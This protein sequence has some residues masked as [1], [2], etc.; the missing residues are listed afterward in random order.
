[1]FVV[2]RLGLI[3]GEAE[4]E[5]KSGLATST[6]RVHECVLPASSFNHSI[7]QYPIKSSEFEV[8]LPLESISTWLK[9]KANVKPLGP[10]T[11]AHYHI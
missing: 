2:G 1:M 4:V 10:A 11:C 5:Y 9:F 3:E 6:M 8:V 7:V